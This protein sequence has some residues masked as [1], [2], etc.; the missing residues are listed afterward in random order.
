MKV[1]KTIKI[2][3]GTIVAILMGAIGSGLW[4]ELLGPAFHFF[5]IGFIRLMSKIFSSYQDS[6]YKSASDG[7]HEFPSMTM[8]IGMLMILIALY[9]W[10]M[11][12]HPH[13]KNSQ[14]KLD[15]TISEFM[16]SKKGYFVTCFI[17]I[18]AIAFLFAIM[19]QIT[20]INK[21]ATY[22]EK[23]INIVSAYID[24]NERLTLKSE[25]ASMKNVE[26]FNNFKLHLEE[27]A[28]V[29]ILELP[30]VESF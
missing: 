20:Y 15:K 27:I 13:A 23:S 10:M 28:D 29:N 2:I 18:T 21:I 9:R 7:F 6:I 30:K 17:S 14:T 16:K 11:L 12:K 26:D 4:E 5:G 25:F 19:I 22:S 1:A 3:L 24:E 8:L